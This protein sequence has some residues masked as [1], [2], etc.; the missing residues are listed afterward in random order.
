MATATSGR[1]DPGRSL[2]Q[3]RSTFLILLPSYAANT[4]TFLRVVA[5]LPL[6]YCVWH[7][8]FHAAA[9]VFAL[10][11]ASDGADGFIARHFQGATRFGAMFDPVAD[12]LLIDGVYLTLAWTGLLPPWLCAAVVVRDVAILCGAFLLKLTRDQ[13]DVRPLVIG[14]VSTL[15]QAALALAVLLEAAGLLPGGGF[16]WPLELAVA[17]LAVLS[18]VI[19]LVA[20]LAVPQA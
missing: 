8:E 7:G 2:A 19:Y 3:A 4:L 5:I 15:A 10:A 13:Y 12:K 11:A 1:R 9:W 16:L 20:A 14:K 17:A 6:L 18:A